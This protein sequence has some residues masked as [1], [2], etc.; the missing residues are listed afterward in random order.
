MNASNRTRNVILGLVAAAGSIAGLS[1]ARSGPADRHPRLRRHAAC[2]PSQ[3]TR[4]RPTDYI[5]ADNNGISSLT[6]PPRRSS[7]HPSPFP[8]A[9][10]QAR[11]GIPP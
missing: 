8:P 3:R 2:E 6:R 1:S 5:D 9:A 11:S 4:A 10:A 7:S